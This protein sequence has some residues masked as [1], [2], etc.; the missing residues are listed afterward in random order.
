MASLLHQTLIFVLFC[1]CFFVVE[2]IDLPSVEAVCKKTQDYN[3]CLK[4]F[5]DDPRTPAADMH[6]LELISISL[7]I[8]QIQATQS[9]NFTTIGKR[10]TDPVGKKRL[11]VCI[12]NYDDALAKFQGAIRAAQNKAYMDVINWI[13]DG[14]N[15]IVECE[16]IYRMGE[17]IAVCPVS[18]ENHKI[19]KLTEITLIINDGF[20][21][22]IST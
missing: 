7:T 18:G 20:I 15:K 16:N 13:R 4:S 2:A 11:G 17:P 19:I 6:G 3:F 1:I 10:I 9:N 8:I 5:T 12:S 21:Q 22:H 14:F